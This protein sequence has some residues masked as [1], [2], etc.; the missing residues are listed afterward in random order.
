MAECADAQIDE[1]KAFHMPM[2]SRPNAVARLI[3]EAAEA[4]SGR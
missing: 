3:E 2:V 4:M 1:V